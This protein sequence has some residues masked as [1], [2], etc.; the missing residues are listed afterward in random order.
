MLT[1]NK[2]YGFADATATTNAGNGKAIEWMTYDTPSTM[3][4]CKYIFYVTL[5]VTRHGIQSRP[6]A[7]RKKRRR[8][9]KKKKSLISKSFLALPCTY[10]RNN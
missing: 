2:Q 6:A 8:K 3:F 4:L 1:T 9:Q 5:N 7:Q 10:T